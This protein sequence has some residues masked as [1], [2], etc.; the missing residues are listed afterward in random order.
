MESGGVPPVARRLLCDLAQL[1]DAFDD[2]SW[3]T[4]VTAEIEATLARHT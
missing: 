1:V 2:A 3:E 4:R